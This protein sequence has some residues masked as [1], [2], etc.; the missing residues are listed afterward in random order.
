MF[1]AIG[2]IGIF[3]P[4][5]PTTPF[6]LL[7]AMCFN[8]SSPKFHQWLL[9]HKVF[10]PPILDWQKNRVIR[11]RSKIMATVVVLSSSVFVLPRENIPQAVKYFYFIFMVFLLGMLWTRKSEV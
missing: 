4:L 6:L 1:L 11:V 2:I 5:L 9:D 7:T 3:L 8:A 10:G